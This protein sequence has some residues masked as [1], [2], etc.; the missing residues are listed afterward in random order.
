MD[1]ENLDLDGHDIMMSQDDVLLRMKVYSRAGDMYRASIEH[2][3]IEL[4]RQA[5]IEVLDGGA[6]V[7]ARI[8]VQLTEDDKVRRS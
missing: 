2:G 3:R 5:P 6:W 4:D 7:K 8:W 1:D